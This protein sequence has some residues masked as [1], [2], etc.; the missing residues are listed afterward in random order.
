[1][2]CQAHAKPARSL[3]SSNASRFFLEGE[4]PPQTASFLSLLLPVF[5]SSH[6][7]FILNPII[8]FII[9]SVSRPAARLPSSRSI[10]HKSHFSLLCFPPLITYT[11]RITLRI[12][13]ECPRFPFSLHHFLPFFLS[14]RAFQ[15]IALVLGPF[16]ICKCAAARP[17]PPC[18]SHQLPGP[19]F[20]KK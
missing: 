1:M 4:F 7:L 16:R 13:E 3:C 9:L 14:F 20:A 5:C 18:L 12:I 10:P 19:C 11:S 15:L 17:T 6:P 8:I 2:P